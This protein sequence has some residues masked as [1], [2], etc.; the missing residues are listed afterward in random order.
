MIFATLLYGLS[1]GIIV[2]WG[3][4]EDEKHLYK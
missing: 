4:Q 2:V 3:F 1:N